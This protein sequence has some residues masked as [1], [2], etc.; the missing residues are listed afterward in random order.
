LAPNKRSQF[1]E[2]T[3]DEIEQMEAAIKNVMA[4]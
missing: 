2:L 4:D 1:A 3:A